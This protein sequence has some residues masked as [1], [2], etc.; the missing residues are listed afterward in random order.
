MIKNVLKI[1]P[2]VALAGTLVGCATPEGNAAL[3]GVIAGAAAATVVTNSR[4]VYG[5]V[6]RPQYCRQVQTYMGRDAWG[7]PVYTIRQVCN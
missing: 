7:Y 5:P 4:P 1:F 3:F 6:Y 2:C